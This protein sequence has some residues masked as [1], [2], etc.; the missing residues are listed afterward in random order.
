MSSFPLLSYR[1]LIDITCRTVES[2]G[3]GVKAMKTAL[4]ITLRL[5]RF[6]SLLPDHEFD[7]LVAEVAMMVSA[8]QNDRLISA[9]EACKRLNIGRTTLWRYMKDGMITAVK[10]SGQKLSFRLSEIEAFITKQTVIDPE[11][12]KLLQGPL[13]KPNDYDHMKSVVKG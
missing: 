3:K 2:Y 13:F 9:E 8:T 6:K 7:N 10:S 1:D 12:Q 11:L 5:A 4:D